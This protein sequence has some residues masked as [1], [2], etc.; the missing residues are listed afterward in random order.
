MSYDSLR[1]SY[2]ESRKY[3]TTILEN[4]EILG[5]ED[6]RILYLLQEEGSLG[7]NIYHMLSDLQRIQR[8]D[9]GLLITPKKVGLDRSM[10]LY[11]LSILR[12]DIEQIEEDVDL[13]NG[14]IDDTI[15]EAVTGYCHSLNKIDDIVTDLKL[16]QSK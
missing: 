9:K 15:R 3:L 10:T 13:A 14:Q 16:N 12:Q 8:K 6:S 5:L 7:K 4:S 1:E 2:L 11:A